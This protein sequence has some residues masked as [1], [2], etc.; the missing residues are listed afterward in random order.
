MVASLSGDHPRARAL[1]R[2]AQATLPADDVEWRAFL[3]LQSNFLAHLT[4]DLLA[5]GRHAAEGLALAEAAGDH[6]LVVV[7]LLQQAHVLHDRGQLTAAEGRLARARGVVER[8]GAQALPEAAALDNVAALV[9]YDRND[10]AEAERLVGSYWA[11]PAAAG[12]SHLGFW[13]GAILARLRAARGDFDGAHEALDEAERCYRGVAPTDASQAPWRALVVPAWR[14]RLDAARG[15]LAAVRSWAD[16][17]A[18]VDL[19]EAPLGYWAHGPIPPMLARARLLTGDPAG[20]LALLT[21]LIARAEAGGAGRALLELTALEAL[22]LE[23]LG[24]PEAADA[25]LTRALALAAPEGAVRPVLDEGAPMA[26]LAR[27]VAGRGG[28]GAAHARALLA[29]FGAGVPEKP[30]A[31]AAR[32]GAGLVERL[33]ERERAVLA[34]TA[35]GRS[36]EEIAGELFLS[37]GT[38]KW[39]LRAIYGKLGAERRTDAV[40]RARALGLLD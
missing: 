26:D 10:L 37:V 8:L 9:R 17:A 20:A 24:R 27:R 6:L 21:G 28:A 40:A 7:M 11:L 32:T 31:P 23:A 39:H 29:A 30:P 16:A 22:A 35:G 15:D 13:A 18:R 33:T 25:A 3:L 34:L 4:G 38:V 14:A 2:E 36:N 1:A 5:A 19:A 12:R